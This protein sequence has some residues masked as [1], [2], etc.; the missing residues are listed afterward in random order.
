MN[1]LA[2]VRIRRMRACFVGQVTHPSCCQL[3]QDTAE[4]PVDARRKS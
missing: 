2:Y 4:E 1:S 3:L